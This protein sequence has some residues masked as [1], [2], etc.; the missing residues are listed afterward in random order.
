MARQ[1]FHVHLKKD[2]PFAFAGLW[3]TW[4]R[5]DAEPLEACTIRHAPDL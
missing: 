4:K 1:P 3:E 5:E 2:H